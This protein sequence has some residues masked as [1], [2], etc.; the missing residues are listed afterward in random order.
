MHHADLVFTL[1]LGSRWAALAHVA[2]SHRR[3][4]ALR[5]WASDVL[6]GLAVRLAPEPE[7]VVPEPHA[8]PMCEALCAASLCDDCRAGLEADDLLRLA[9][10]DGVV[11]ES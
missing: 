5:T 4:R 10:G 7:A 8:C 1:I 2:L 6:F 3:V 11:L 9:F